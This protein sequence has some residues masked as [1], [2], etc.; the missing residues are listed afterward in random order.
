MNWE[1]LSIDSYSSAQELYQLKR[2][3]SCT[4]R[5]YYSAYAAIA[6]ALPTGIAFPHGWLN[7]GHHQLPDLVRQLARLT[8]TE[9]KDVRA[10]LNLL[11]RRREDADY[12]PAQRTSCLEAHESL[13]RARAVLQTLGVPIP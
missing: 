3:R 8:P 1:T 10:S 4:S 13:T 7:P 2:W 9:R 11:R 6:H 5:A 12:R